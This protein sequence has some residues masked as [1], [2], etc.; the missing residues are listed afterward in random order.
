MSISTLLL[1]I[2]IIFLLG[3]FRDWGAGPFY[4]TG[5]AGGGTLG[6]IVV[7]LIILIL[8]GKI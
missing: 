2:L 3:G 1:I 5:T 4:G 8:F 7:V 6:L